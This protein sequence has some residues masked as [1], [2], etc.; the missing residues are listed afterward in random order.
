VENHEDGITQD[1]SQ[2]Y[3]VDVSDDEGGKNGASD[4]INVSDL[5]Q[6]SPMMN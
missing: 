5:I 2:G 4:N 6:S 3:E 1:D